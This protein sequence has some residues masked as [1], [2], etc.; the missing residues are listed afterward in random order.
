MATVL[1]FTLY[2]G[3]FTLGGMGLMWILDHTGPDDDE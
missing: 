1:V 3:I 2:T